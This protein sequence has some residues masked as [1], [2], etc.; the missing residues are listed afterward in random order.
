MAKVNPE[1]GWIKGKTGDKAG[2]SPTP[3]QSVPGPK[4][5]PKPT[6]DSGPKKKPGGK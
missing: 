1:S 3:K 4:P 2:A 6:S 5:S